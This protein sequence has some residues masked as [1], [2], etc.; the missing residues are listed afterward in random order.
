MFGDIPFAG[1]VGVGLGFSL[2]VIYGRSMALAQFWRRLEA[3]LRQLNDS[4]R[5]SVETTPGQPLTLEEF[6]A[7]LKQH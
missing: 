6:L 2:G 3:R 7:V 1:A 5:I 4:H